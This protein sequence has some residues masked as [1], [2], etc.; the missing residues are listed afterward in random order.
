METASNASL[1]ASSSAVSLSSSAVS[2]SSFASAV[3]AGST[4]PED[5][6][7]LQLYMKDGRIE[8]TKTANCQHNALSKCVYCISKEP[9]D[10]AYLR[11]EG[12]KHMSFHAYLR[13]LSGGVTKGKFAALEDISCKI[14]KGC[15]THKPWPE[16]VCSKC[17]PPAITLNRQQYRHVDNVMFENAEVR[18]KSNIVKCI[19]LIPL[20]LYRL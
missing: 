16:S 12:I 13:K 6:V 10:E 15:T 9:Y 17:L 1:S 8:Q 2:L 7:D 11:Q 5:D 4:A 19:M 3:N 18:N 14:K 20:C